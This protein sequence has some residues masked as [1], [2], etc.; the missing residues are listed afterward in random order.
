MVQLFRDPI[1]LR[2]NRTA[3]VCLCAPPV[4]CVADHL[5]A[6]VYEDY[7][8]TT[9]YVVTSAWKRASA[10]ATVVSNCDLTVVCR[11]GSRRSRGARVR[12]RAVNRGCVEPAE[13]RSV[14]VVQRP[15]DRPSVLFL[16]G[17]GLVQI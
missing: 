7:D 6:L 9:I 13:P 8:R 4:S 5:L 17:R 1:R 14:G 3:Y 12:S 2:V 10:P 16:E 11:S 15:I